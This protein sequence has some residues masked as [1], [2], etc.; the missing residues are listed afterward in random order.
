[1]KITDIDKN[2]SVPEN[3][4]YDTMVF[5]NIAER[6]FSIHGVIYE[7][8][9]YRR[10][11]ADISAK[12]S[13]NVDFLS[14]CTAGGRVRF[15]T[16]SG[17]IAIHAK[18]N[19]VGKMP[20]F[21]L[22]GSSGF[23]VFADGIYCGTAVPAFDIVDTIDCV[24]TIDDESIS[25][26]QIL[27]NMPPYSGVTELYIGLDE[28]SSVKEPSGY[29]VSVPVVFYGSSI[30]QGGCCSRAGTTYQQILSHRL[31]FDYINLGFSGSALAETEIAE[32]IAGLNM[33][34]F[35]YDYDHNAPHVEHLMATHEGMFHTIRDS[36]PDLPILFM[37]RPKKHLTDEEKQRLEI[38]KRTFDNAVL[39]GDKN[40]YFIQ[41]NELFPDKYAEFC[42]VDNCHPTDLGFMCMADTIE[43]VLK[44]MLGGEN[45]ER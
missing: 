2:F 36:H 15:V 4:E 45:I 20:H 29:S 26:R 43:P 44:Q 19:S 33:S 28:K 31:D 12:V 10:L 27:I 3:P 7:N 17:R 11:P 5:H 40:V 41:G 38:V 21:A 39:S 25:E 13:N 37:T 23:D 34:A 22:T 16:D 24:I 8:D 30:T 18:L 32:Y 14:K 6:E 1:M 42:L 35:V 9:I